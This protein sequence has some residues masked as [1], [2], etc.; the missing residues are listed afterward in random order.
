MGLIF[1]IKSKVICYSYVDGLIHRIFSINNICG[2]DKVVIKNQTELSNFLE[3]ID[4]YIYTKE[5]SIKN[6]ELKSVPQEISSLSNLEYLDVGYNNISDF[7]MFL[8]TMP[9][10][11]VIY[12][13]N[14]NGN[15]KNFP[16]RALRVINNIKVL[17]LG[18]NSLQTIPAFIYDIK[19]LRYLNLENNEITSIPEEINNL[20]NLTYLN[21]LDN[22]LK[23]IKLNN[24]I[25][26]LLLDK[27]SVELLPE[28]L[29]NNNNTN[30]YN[31][32]QYFNINAFI[33]D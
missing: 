1:S 14:Q 3:N 32:S 26:Y 16:E 24:P 30:I 4:K 17:E 8:T 28:G 7:P 19:S 33:Y 31:Y 15:L 20:N 6:L 25:L 23:S 5:L 29:R 11:R 13:H 12:I 21:I 22:E 9:N 27:E 2:K 10:L 18:N